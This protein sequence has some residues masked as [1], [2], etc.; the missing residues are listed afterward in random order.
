MSPASLTFTTANWNSAQT[1]TATGVDDAVADGNQPYSIVTASASSGDPGYNGLNPA[2]VTVTNTDNEPSPGI[3]VN[4]VSGLVTTEG[5]G[6]ASFT[7]VLKTQPTA[8]VTI[9]LS[10]SDTTEGTVSP[11][12]L[13]FTTANWNSAQTVTVTGVDDAVADGSQPYSIVTAPASSSD[14]GYNGLNP[15]NV[16][17]TNTD[18]EPARGITVNPVSGLVTTEGGGTASFTVVLN[19]PPAASVTIGLSSSDTTE[20]TVSP[21]SLTFTT[22]N[23]SSA[24]TVT[25]TG[26]DDA[27]ADGLQRYS[28][29]TAPA[30]SADTG[31]N[32]MDPADVSVTST[33]NEPALPIGNTAW[34]Y[35]FTADG[36]LIPGSAWYADIVDAGETP[37]GYWLNQTSIAAPYLF[38]GDFAA[39]FEFYLKVLPGENIYRYAFRLIDPNWANIHRKYASFGAYY[40]AFPV[41]HPDAYYDESQG[42][43]WYSYEAHPGSVAG[44][45]SGVNTCRITRI[46]DTV[47]ITMNGELAG[48]VVVDPLNQPAAGYSPL[49]FGQNSGVEAD[50]NF[51]VRKLT[52]MYYLGERVDHNWN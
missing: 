11:A 23:W 50:S 46:G 18:N 6:T 4:P 49:V 37:L 9:G 17:V 27:I 51:Y 24:Q 12:S 22:A 26:V 2:D 34:I 48:T 38:T 8:S 7:V 40:T 20:G 32:G 39:E 47:T 16:S 28:L 25:V 13:T 15:A 5:G 29:I 19:A 21:A 10:S 36:D 30:G 14:L 44:V 33:D 43:G 52:V 45:T 1:V 41:A 42:N 35:D 3:T 31:Y